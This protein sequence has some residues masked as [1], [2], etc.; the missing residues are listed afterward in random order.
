MPNDSI[1]APVDSGSISIG[2]NWMR[3]ECCFAHAETVKEVHKTNTDDAPKGA[4]NEVGVAEWES[5]SHVCKS[6]GESCAVWTNPLL[7][8]LMAEKQGKEVADDA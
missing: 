2:S 8:R 3:S 6:C 4:L 7:A 1:G 5:I